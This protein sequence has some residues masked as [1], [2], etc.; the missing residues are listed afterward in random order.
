MRTRQGWGEIK[1]KKIL[2]TGMA[3]AIVAGSTTIFA[4]VDPAVELLA[5]Y[6]K[7]F[8]QEQV[9]IDATTSEQLENGLDKAESYLL[10]LAEEAGLK[11]TESAH[12]NLQSAQGKIDDYRSDIIQDLNQV[13]RVLEEQELQMDKHRIMEDLEQELSSILYEAFGE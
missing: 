5:W 13:T 9:L 10:E 2:A 3:L 6:E 12:L 8:S 4:A 7:E 11:I 1:I